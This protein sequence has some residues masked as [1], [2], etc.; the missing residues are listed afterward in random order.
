[1]LL[2]VPS[3]GG[4]STG[5]W[6]GAVQFPYVREHIFSVA[7]L[8]SALLCVSLTTANLLLRW[9]RWHF[10]IRGSTPQLTTRDS[11]ATYLA[12]LPAIVTPFLV[13]ELVRVWILRRRFRT[14]TS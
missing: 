1:M 10:L 8:V 2:A 3:I 13:G 11:I 9:I 7:G 6:I 4:L 12:T 5:L 14:P